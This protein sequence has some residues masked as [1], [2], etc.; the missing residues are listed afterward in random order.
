MLRLRSLLADRH[1]GDTCQVPV[2][3]RWESRSLA[4]NRWIVR[5]LYTN[6][7]NLNT[8][9]KVKTINKYLLQ[10]QRPIKLSYLYNRPW[11]PVGLWDVEAPTF[12]RESAHRC[13]WGCQ[14][15]GHPLPPGRFLVLI[16]VRGWVDLRVI[17][18]LEGLGQL[19]NSMTSSWLEPATSWLQTQCLNQ[20]LY[21][22]LPI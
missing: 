21:H 19:K 10:W 9:M 6:S 5:K 15:Y 3:E 22:V 12:S 1:V 13:R 16:S 17:V 4:G 14:P 7:N 2:E 11:R 8:F 20:L 18:R